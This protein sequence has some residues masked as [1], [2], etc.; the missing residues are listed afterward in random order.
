[1]S[2]LR[3]ASR[4]IPDQERRIMR[5]LLLA[6]TALLAFAAMPARA[7]VI[8]DNHLSGTGD[9]VIFNALTPGVQV[10]G[11]FN[12][13]HQG[14]VDFNCFQSCAGYT[15]AQ[16]GNDL[17]INN[18]QAISVQV[19]A[20]DKTTVLPTQTD[21][22][23][24]TGTGHVTVVATANEPG[25]GTMPVT[26]DLFS[27]FGALGPGQ[28]GFTLKAINGE[29]IDHFTLVDVGGTLT[30]F[31]HYRIDVAPAVNA[32]PGPIAGAGLPGLIAACAG[33]MAFARRRRNKVA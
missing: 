6:T 25:G 26:F 17:K 28:N 23:S 33:L 13:Q 30:D 5:K 29:T 12:G 2:T 18:F 20:N 7:D 19:F 24:I 32:V 1:M 27:L 3:G 31:E 11:A 9:N 14:F 22:F 10:V 16:N 15:G 4:T 21:V 8:I